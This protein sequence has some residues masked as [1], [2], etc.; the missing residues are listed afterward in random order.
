MKRI[1][2]IRE[3]HFGTCIQQNKLTRLF[4]QWSPMTLYENIVSVLSMTD[5]NNVRHLNT[6]VKLHT[7]EVIEYIR[8]KT[9]DFRSLIYFTTC[10]E[11]D[12]D[13]AVD[14]FMPYIEAESDAAK[15]RYM[16]EIKQWYVQKIRNMPSLDLQDLPAFIYQPPGIAQSLREI[17][18]HL[19]LLISMSVI[20]FGVAFVA[21]LKYD[22]R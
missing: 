21:L 22:I 15:D 19:G 4:S 6:Q 2:E 12:W 7:D 18:M 8:S 3:G 5:L 13:E 16:D 20:F 9:N 10:T 17:M 14:H 1:R 11:Q